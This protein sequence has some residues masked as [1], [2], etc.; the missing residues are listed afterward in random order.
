[1]K[2]LTAEGSGCVYFETAPKALTKG[3]PLFQSPPP[4]R[5]I[6]LIHPDS[7]CLRCSLP[8]VLNCCLLC[9]PAAKFLAAFLPGVKE[10]E[11]Y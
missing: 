4:A 1:M 7:P 6:V 3:M 2:E 10:I 8:S 11:A 9:F 5:D